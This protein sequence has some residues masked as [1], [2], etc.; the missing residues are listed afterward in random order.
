M[1]HN[2]R[3]TGGRKLGEQIAELLEKEII[4]GGWQV[5]TVLGSESDLLE[6]FD[7]S[8]AVMREAIRVLEHHGVATMRRGPGGGLIVTAPDARAAVRA[9]S[10]VLG[11][12]DATPQHIFQARSALELKCVEL[13]TERI[14]EEGIVRLRQA[15]AAES[16]QQGRG[17]LGNQDLHRLI[18]ELTGNPALVLFVDVLTSLVSGS[19][20]AFHD[21]KSE[22]VRVAH[23]KIA[24][25]VVAGDVALARRRMQV[26]L[27]AIGEWMDRAHAKEAAE[28][29]HTH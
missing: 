27:A 3:G 23:D 14:D 1:N 25:A 28:G 4:D 21:A 15:L 17:D 8:R 6:R 19:R 5:G 20:E 18:A 2:G 12:M 16:E 10:L 7:V 24:E 22:E 26:H 29:V 9:S 13:A 11:Y